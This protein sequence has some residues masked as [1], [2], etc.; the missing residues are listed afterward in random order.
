VIWRRGA[1]CSEQ[2][3][4]SIITAES[5]AFLDE[6]R[7]RKQIGCVEQLTLSAK[8]ADALVLIDLEMQKEI[9]NGEEN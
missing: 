3:P 9:N 5:L 1:V 6:Y 2:C 4:K 8:A 7:T